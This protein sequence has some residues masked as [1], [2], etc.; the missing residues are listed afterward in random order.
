MK[1][2]VYFLLILIAAVA[3]ASAGSFAEAAGKKTRIDAAQDIDALG[4]N[5]DLMERAAALNAETRSRIVQSR[6]VDR[7]HRLEL[8][9]LY[10]GNAGGDSYL[11]SQMFGASMDYHINPRV[12]LGVRYN[13]YRNDL[14]PE[15]QRVF[16]QAREAYSQGGRAYVIP[17]IDYPLESLIATVNWYPIYGKTN[18]LDWGIAQFDMYLLGGGGQMKL[19]SG[20]TSVMTGGAGLG[21]WINQHVTARAELRYQNYKDQVITGSRNIQSVV[22][23]L[24]LGWIL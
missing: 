16:D 14:T 8:G 6:V 23:T 20:S 2:Q 19:S 21:F 12:S 22:G 7:H 24:A 18:L 13:N 3:L 5:E 4:G 1:Q 9:V 17:D 15:G 11:Q 10:G